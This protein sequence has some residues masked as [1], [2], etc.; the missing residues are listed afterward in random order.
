MFPDAVCW[1]DLFE[2]TMSA[3]RE[4]IEVPVPPDLQPLSYR[5]IAAWVRD[6]WGRLGLPWYPEAIS[7]SEG[8]DVAYAYET[9]EFWPRKPEGWGELWFIE[10]ERGET[11]TAKIGPLCFVDDTHEHLY[12]QAR[13]EVYEAVKQRMLGMCNEQIDFDVMCRSQETKPHTI[14]VSAKY[15]TILG[16]RRLA[17]LPALELPTPRPRRSE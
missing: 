9:K 11:C 14:L 7:L 10:N 2:K 16:S 1:G 3:R 6:N 8:H 12:V 15:N 17:I 13:P 4:E 5:E